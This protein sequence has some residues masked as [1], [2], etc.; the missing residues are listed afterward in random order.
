MMPQSYDPSQSF[1]MENMQDFGFFSKTAN[2]EHDILSDMGSQFLMPELGSYQGFPAFPLAETWTPLNPAPPPP[3]V[4][5]LQQPA[6]K[7]QYPEQESTFDHVSPLLG[8]K[9]LSALRSPEQVSLAYSEVRSAY[10][11]STGYHYLLKYTQ[12]KYSPDTTCT[13]LVG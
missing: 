8:K 12:D 5:P 10:C 11:Y 13:K 7:P 6:E 4:T 9:D 2:L 3:S 1:L